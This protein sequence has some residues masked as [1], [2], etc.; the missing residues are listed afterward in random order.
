MSGTYQPILVV[1]SIAIAMLASF[2]ALELVTRVTA[3]RGRIRIEQAL[4]ESEE[5]FRTM[6][7]SLADGIVLQLADFSISTCN[8]SAE[9]ITG[10]TA[11]QMLGR[12]P[13][14]EG[15]LAIRED[16][17][18]FDLR[19][20]P[21]IIA[22]VTGRPASSMMGVQGTGCDT[23]WISI[24]TRPLTHAGSAKPYAALSSII[25]VSR[26]WSR[27]PSTSSVHLVPTRTC[28]ATAC[29]SRYRGAGQR[30]NAPSSRWHGN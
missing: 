17:S 10:L 3:T 6:I 26:S 29:G 7:D 15:W 2:V 13:R 9:R 14:P 5:R 4:R 27:L 12:A 24:N 22:L 18:R 1:L 23:R 11:E 19:D 20:H 21:S 30:R 16:G 25:D 28:A 8:A